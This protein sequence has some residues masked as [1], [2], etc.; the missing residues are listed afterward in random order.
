[1]AQN[2]DS[3][4]DVDFDSQNIFDEFSESQEI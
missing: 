4:G 1:M 3:S 2:K